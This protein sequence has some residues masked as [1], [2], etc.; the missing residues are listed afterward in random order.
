MKKN[1]RT[2]LSQATINSYVNGEKTTNIN[3]GN[4]ISESLKYGQNNIG[5]I[6]V[7]GLV[8]LLLLFLLPWTIAGLMIGIYNERVNGEKLEVS[9]LFKGFDHFLPILIY[10]IIAVAIPMII[11]VILGIVPVL[12]EGT[13]L[14]TIL[15]IFA[16]LSSYFIGFLVTGLLFFSLHFIIF[17]SMEPVEAIKSSLKIAKN[18]LIYVSLA[19][20]VFNLIGGVG[21]LLCG[22]GIFFTYPL[23]LLAQY[24]AI[25][26]EFNTEQQQGS[27]DDILKHLV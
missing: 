23:G 8:M 7:I 11:G 1:Y 22:I 26:E 16:Q 9:T 18:N 12:F 20:L 24:F 25:A 5:N 15:A 2:A 14:G 17:A 6:L 10:T 3:I 27:T 13:A 4:A 19:A 21:A